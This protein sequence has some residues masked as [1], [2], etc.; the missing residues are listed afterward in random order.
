MSAFSI[1]TGRQTPPLIDGMVH[2]RLVQQTMTHL[3]YIT[4]LVTLSLS[5]K[6]VNAYPVLYIFFRFWQCKDY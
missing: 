2:N 4:S 3:L 6:Q 1:D 5:N